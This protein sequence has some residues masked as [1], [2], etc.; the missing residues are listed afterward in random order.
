MIIKLTLFF[1]GVFQG[2]IRTNCN[3]MVSFWYFSIKH[4]CFS[5]TAGEEEVATTDGRG[6]RA[7]GTG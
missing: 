7:A 2:G 6:L 4:D 5:I 3:T 1:G